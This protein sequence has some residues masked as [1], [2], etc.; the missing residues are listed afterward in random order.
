M[1]EEINNGSTAVDSR[2]RGRDGCQNDLGYAVVESTCK[3]TTGLPLT[4][5]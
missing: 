5:A 1:L 3:T 2:G 4:L